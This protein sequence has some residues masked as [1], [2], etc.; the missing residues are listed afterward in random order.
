MEAAFGGL[1]QGAFALARRAVG[2]A[3]RKGMT[4]G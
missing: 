2:R 1:L 4:N 3:L